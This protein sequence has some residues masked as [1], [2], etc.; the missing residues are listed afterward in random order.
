MPTAKEL[1]Y[2]II[3]N[4]PY[5]FV[6]PKGMDPAVVKALH[7]GFKK[8]MDDPKHLEMLDT[9]NQ[10]LWYRSGDEYAKW[11]P[12]PY[13]AGQVADRA[14]RPAGQVMRR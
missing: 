2:D 1:G 13:R 12:R 3:G 14:A 9:L 10:D 11:A 4:S 7:D 5:G 8:A 6:G